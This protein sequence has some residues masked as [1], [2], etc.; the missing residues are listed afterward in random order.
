[1]DT[2]LAAVYDVVYSEYPG[3]PEIPQILF[4]IPGNINPESSKVLD[5]GAGM[6][7]FSIPL[8][9]SGFQVESV[10]ISSVAIEYIRS[11]A[12]KHNLKITARKADILDEGVVGDC[13]III[14]SFVCHHLLDKDA[15]SLF[16]EMKQ[17]TLSGGINIIAV[18]TQ[19][20]DF[21]KSELVPGKFYPR[22]GELFELYADWDVIMCTEMS[23]H[24]GYFED[25][26]PCFNLNSY[27]LAQKPTAL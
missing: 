16:Q 13:E 23:S 8:A 21:F 20:G 17:H 18:H 10:D 1:M 26:S 4:W 22:S 2:K 27:L 14:C 24:S 15:R 7:A 6:G 12:Y 3:L 25:G 11:T 5:I 9:F 19:E